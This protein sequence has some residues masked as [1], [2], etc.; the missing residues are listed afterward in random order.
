MRSNVVTNIVL[1]RNWSNATGNA[2]KERQASSTD[3]AAARDSCGFVFLCPE[4][5]EPVTS[6]WLC[7]ESLADAA[8]IRG[9]SAARDILC[10]DLAL[11][12]RSSRLTPGCAGLPAC[13]PGFGV[14]S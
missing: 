13:L 2:Q 3:R 7:L 9:L 12:S 8:G 11:N 4:K 14:C 1:S 6:S 10:S 5:L